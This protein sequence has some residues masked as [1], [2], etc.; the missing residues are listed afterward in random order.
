MHKTTRLFIL[1]S[2]LGFGISLNAQTTVLD[3][4]LLTQQSF[5]TFTRVSVTGAQ[6]WNFSSQYGAVCSGFFSGQSNANEDWLVSAPM[7]LSPLN[8]VQL[9]FSHARGPE[10]LINVGVAQGWYKAFAT[11]NY[12][13][14]PATTTWV[15][16]TGLNQNITQGWQ[17]VASGALVI[18]AA[19]KSA[20]SRIAFRYMS[21]ASQSAT[22]EIKNVKVTG[23]QEGME[24][25][26]VT[27]WNTEW[28]GCTQFGP[29]DESGQVSNVAQAML[30][31][32][33]DV[34]CLQE[35]TN[36]PSVPTIAS[37]VAQMGSSEWGGAIVP[38]NTGDC[39]QRQGII[40]KKS[41]VQLVN[42][43]ELTNGNGAQGN[44]YYNNW[45]GGR[46]PS[47][48]N[49]NFIAGNNAIPVSLVNIHAKAEDG[50]ASS[51]TRRKGGS[52]G[53]KGILDGPA[54][55]TKNVIVIGD[56]NDY[57]IGTTS[58]ACNCSV[59]PYKNFMD[60]A[61]NYNG[62]TKDITDVVTNWGIRPLIENIIIS[63]ELVDNYSAGS[64]AQEVSVAG[65]I[66]DY[67]NTTSNHLPVT[68]AF[69]F[70]T[71]GAPEFTSATWTVYP[72]PVKDELNITST[73]VM[74]DNH[75]TIYDLTGRQ[76]FD[77]ELIG[78]S[79]NVSALPAG[80]YIL[81]LDGR[82]RKFVKE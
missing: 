46:F 34:Y 24:T 26:R 21:S 60:D 31:M 29:I 2:F 79:I 28:L 70:Q 59:S 39:N 44:S 42:S 16:L 65:S 7:N 33:S 13:G 43:T 49:V 78:E 50:N 25:F 73:G 52:E 18:P 27:N 62:I 3:E 63:S 40:Y 68:A 8:N 77:G 17:Y 57:L 82:S 74:E 32:D 51:Y 64:A 36:T 4:T 6:E 66:D 20:Q 67:Y 5:N 45:S 35:V 41:R 19:A 22:W 56:F 47:V 55:N 72:N 75:T 23:Q 10:A 81:K 71:L 58:D 69:Q 48:Y 14:N 53:L 30:L 15:E 61:A 12:T 76:V 1:L 80:I 11:A 54:Y 38:S 9:S 37:I